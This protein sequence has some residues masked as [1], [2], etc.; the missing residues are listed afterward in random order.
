MKTS[1]MKH[2]S[3]ISVIFL[4]VEFYLDHFQMYYFKKIKQCISLRAEVLSLFRIQNITTKEKL[5]YS[6]HTQINIQH[7]FKRKQPF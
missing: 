2:I 6:K 1:K 3:L 5:N 7:I 4:N